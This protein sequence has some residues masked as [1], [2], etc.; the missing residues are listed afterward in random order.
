MIIKKYGLALGLILLMG[1]T[2][3]SAALHEFDWTG[4]L[5]VSGFRPGLDES[6]PST[7]ADPLTMRFEWQIDSDSSFSI[8]TPTG[9]ALTTSGYFV[10]LNLIPGLHKVMPLD[11]ITSTAG[12]Y[13]VG[14]T[15]FPPGMDPAF[16]ATGTPLP[17]A[18]VAMLDPQNSI[19]SVLN[20]NEILF[21]GSLLVYKMTEV[22]QPDPITGISAS[23]LS[24]NFALLDL[25]GNSDGIVSRSFIL[26]ASIS[27]V[28]LPAAFWLMGSAVLG[29]MGFSRN[30]RLTRNLESS[31]G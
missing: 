3:L 26:N 13:P 27:E 17:L 28:P 29:F 2:S 23:S 11:L 1:S 10:I 19:N 31:D 6:D 18:E 14:S 5:T 9:A 7:D 22:P 20:V 8:G 16:L 30:K 4:Q 12:L 21:D 25:Q 15:S 24:G